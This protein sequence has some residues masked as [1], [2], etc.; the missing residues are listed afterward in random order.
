MLSCTCG[1]PG[2]DDCNTHLRAEERKNCWTKL[3]AEG[4]G[5]QNY[6]F[7]ELFPMLETETFPPRNPTFQ[8][9][10]GVG[11]FLNGLYYKYFNSK[12][13]EQSI[14][15]PI[16]KSAIERIAKEPGEYKFP[17]TTFWKSVV[18]EIENNRKRRQIYHANEHDEE[19]KESPVRVV[20][21]HHG[22][23]ASPPVLEGE[24]PHSKR[25]KL[26]TNHE[27]EELK[28]KLE[29]EEQNKMKADDLIRVAELAKQRA[30]EEANLLKKKI[31]EENIKADILS[32][33]NDDKSAV[34]FIKRVI[35]H[36]MEAMPEN[37]RKA[38]RHEETFFQHKI[39]NTLK[40][41]QKMRKDKGLVLLFD[42]EYTTWK[43]EQFSGERADFVIHLCEP[44]NHDNRV[45]VELKRLKEDNFKRTLPKHI[46]QV[47]GHAMNLQNEGFRCETAL[48]INLPQ[49]ESAGDPEIRVLRGP[50]FDKIELL[51]YNAEN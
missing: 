48:L 10:Y 44:T 8:N 29:L 6:F 1:P 34:S 16:F 11:S 14:I 31:E 13:L 43:D 23:A 7:L 37:D 41:F 51:I 4:K 24:E 47:R 9:L 38:P 12:K 3:P 39:H 30:I 22:P 49:G 20:V 42:R 17:G 28:K 26:G 21:E 46:D 15:I 5:C 45:V 2:T 32:P 33:L 36:T 19:I 25:L 40:E 50:K 35:N 18:L 27:L